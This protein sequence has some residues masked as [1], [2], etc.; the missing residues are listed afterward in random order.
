VHRRNLEALAARLTGKLVVD[1]DEVIP[2]LGE[3]GPVGVVGVARRPV[4]A[5]AP[6]PP[7]LIVAGPLAAGTGVAAVALLG[8]LVEEGALVQG[9]A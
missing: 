9:H 2:Q 8:F 3:L 7:Q 4:L 6:H 5:C 1:P